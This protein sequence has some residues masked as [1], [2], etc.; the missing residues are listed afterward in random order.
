MGKLQVSRAELQAAFREA[1]G[2]DACIDFG[3]IEK[4][5]MK[6]ALPMNISGDMAYWK[7]M[8]VTDDEFISML[9]RNGNILPDLAPKDM[10][11]EVFKMHMPDSVDNGGMITLDTMHAIVSNFSN[12]WPM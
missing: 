2:E 1:A 5:E 12:E 4:V 7:D 9:E 8:K 6:Y 11:M 3:E 10:V